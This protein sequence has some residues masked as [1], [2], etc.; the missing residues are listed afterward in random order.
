MAGVN[1]STSA[2]PFCPSEVENEGRA[3]KKKRKM[4]RAE[5]ERAELRRGFMDAMWFPHLLPLK[6]RKQR[7]TQEAVIRVR[8]VKEPG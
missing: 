7:K 2:G 1:E 6:C 3:K 4:K 8:K 5:E